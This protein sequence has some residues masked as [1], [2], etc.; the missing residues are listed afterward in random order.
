MLH[1]TSFHI[2]NM[3]S[4]SGQNRAYSDTTNSRDGV[5]QL[6]IRK[7]SKDLFE[8]LQSK[9]LSSCNSINI[10]DFSTLYATIPL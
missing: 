3:Y 8:Y 10:F 7:N 6:W 1:E 4:I 5:N 2:I 9:S